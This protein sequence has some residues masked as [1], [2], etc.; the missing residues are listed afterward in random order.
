M[1][2]AIQFIL[3]LTPFANIHAMDDYAEVLTYLV[4]YWEW[5]IEAYRTYL[6]PNLRTDNA[7][8]V[9]CALVFL[10]MAEWMHFVYSGLTSEELRV[11]H[12]FLLYVCMLVELRSNVSMPLVTVLLPSWLLFLAWA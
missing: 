12:Y 8:I 5:D 10:T 7:Y 3:Q 2:L 11:R 4:E 9:L 6:N 1:D